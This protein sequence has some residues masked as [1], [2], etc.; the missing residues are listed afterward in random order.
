MKNPRLRFFHKYGIY[1]YGAYGLFMLLLGLNA[2]VIFFISPLLL[3]WIGF[4][5]L[6]YFAHKDGAVRDVPLM[7]VLAPGEGWHK[8][9]HEHPSYY[10]LNKL[11]IAGVT[12]ERFF[13]K[14][15]SSS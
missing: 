13:I 2:F 7:N 11:D 12:I 14:S 1:M 9:H 6:N 10:K 4:G 8:V 5:L 15:K 3:S